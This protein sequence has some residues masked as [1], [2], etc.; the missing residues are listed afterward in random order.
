MKLSEFLSMAWDM[1]WIFLIIPAI[2]AIMWLAK[3]IRRE[4]RGNAGDRE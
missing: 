4:D 1:S 3:Q 2:A